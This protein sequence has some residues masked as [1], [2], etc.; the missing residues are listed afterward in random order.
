MSERHKELYTHPFCYF[1]SGVESKNHFELAKQAGVKTFLMAF[2][3]VKK[4]LGKREEMLRRFG[5]KEYRLIVDSSTY[6]FH[7]KLDEYGNEDKYPLEYWE[8]F[9]DEY[10]TWIEEHAEQVMCFVE[11]DI[12][13]VVG[14]DKVLEWREE[15]IEPFEERT[16]I[17]CI[18]MWQPEYDLKMWEYMCKRY[19][20]VGF[21]GEAGIPDKQVQKM[22]QIAKKHNTLVHGM[23]KWRGSS[24]ITLNEGHP[25]A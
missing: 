14:V 4:N 9:L 18:Y 20:Y 25:N 2:L 22:L 12:T 23:A 13:G 1:T 5:S 11:L 17:P 21:S 3:H 15:I 19:H 10:L 16:G 7:T 8:N 6:T 24:K